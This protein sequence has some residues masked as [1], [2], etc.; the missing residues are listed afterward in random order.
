M[1]AVTP[2]QQQNYLNVSRTLRAWL[3]TRDHK[4]IALLYLLSITAFFLI[5]ALAAAMM[6]LELLTPA[7]D[8]V[9]ADTYNKLFT[10][11]G[12]VMVW[13]FLIPSIPATFGNFLIPLM[14]G[15]RDVAFPR[16]NLASW[17]LYSAGG[18]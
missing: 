10:V 18:L 5:A 17:Y 3:S 16:L 4:R 12:V 15:A 11:H 7:G 14:I 1:S 6:R 9:D 8:L 2:A 13:F